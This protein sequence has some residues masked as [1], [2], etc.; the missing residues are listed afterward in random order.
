M[1]EWVLF[2]DFCGLRVKLGYLWKVL[3]LCVQEGNFMEYIM[4]IVFEYLMFFFM[5]KCKRGCCYW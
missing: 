4:R 5:L 3:G 1:D 2:R